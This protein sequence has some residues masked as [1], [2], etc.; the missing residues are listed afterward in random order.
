MAATAYPAEPTDLF[1][2]LYDALP[3]ALFRGWTATEWHDDP[4]VR[5]Q[6]G[7]ISEIVLDT[8]VLDPAVTARHVEEKGDLG[9][10]TVLLGLDIALAHVNPY[11]PYHD[12]PALTGALVNYLT[13]GRFNGP[14]T[15]GALLPRCA[16]PGR[17]LGRRTKAEFF[18]LHRIPPDEWERIDHSV[19]PAVNDPHFTRDQPVTVGC[20]PVLE[21]FDDIEIDFERRHGMTVYRLRPMDSVMV[22]TRIKAIIRRL[23]ESGAQLAVMPEL[24]LSDSL[25]EH[26]KEVAFDTADRDRD[27]RPLRF[28][29]LGTGPL[30]T[31]D[32]PPNRAVLLDRWTGQELLVQDKLSGFTLDAAQMRL[33]RLPDAPAA[34]T[35]EE[36]ATPGSKISLLDSSL[37][38][39]AVLICE[40][41]SRSI[42]WE[43]E[44]LSCGVSHLLVP[45]FSKPILEH[46]WEQQGAE[47]QVGS[48]G[49]WVTVANSL[50]VG[51]AIPHSEMPERRYTCLVAG[52]ESLARTAYSLKLQ[53]GAAEAGDQLGLTGDPSSPLPAVLPGAAYD[54]WHP[55]WPP[56]HPDRDWM[57]R[58]GAWRRVRRGAPTRGRCHACARCR[59][60]PATPV[61]LISCRSPGHRG[62]ERGR[63][64]ACLR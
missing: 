2:L 12:A 1:V 38:R 30:G 54:L 11:G 62:R 13:D 49:T 57:R 32:P 28:I 41:L 20:A 25:L 50:V 42:G 45:I 47:R 52:P 33:W 61:R 46:R 55:H 64:R 24:S 58:P 31:T 36:Y 27:R 18:G 5:R 19:L 40:D 16:F 60:R 14:G 8:G 29:L 48:L 23:D 21:S 9:R 44:L 34:G 53:F 10:F 3:D 26:W 56:P 43:R 15:Q 39:L 35:A 4:Q 59:T 7:E 22:R 37:G 17:P 51:T 63:F 6:A